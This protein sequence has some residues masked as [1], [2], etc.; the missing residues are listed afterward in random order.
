MHRACAFERT[1]C[2][3]GGTYGL[4]PRTGNALRELRIENWKLRN[5][6]LGEPLRI[7]RTR[8]VRQWPNSQFSILHSRARFE[9]L[10]RYGWN[11]DAG[12]TEQAARAF[13]SLSSSIEERVG[14]RSRSQGIVRRLTGLAYYRLF[15]S[16]S[17]DREMR[18]GC[19]V[20]RL[21][22]KNNQPRTPA[23]NS[24]TT[25]INK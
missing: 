12:C 3:F 22:R 19:G 4:V 13:L 16:L 21:L 11:R 17:M 18:L 2:A 7:V 14:V 20:D 9:P 23:T 10:N 1:P 15:S 24:T 6:S 5:G 8:I 25:P